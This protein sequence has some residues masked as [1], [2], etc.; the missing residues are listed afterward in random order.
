MPR[1]TKG[2]RGVAAGLPGARAAAAEAPGGSPGSERHRA[3]M[4]ER[5]AGLRAELDLRQKLA[6]QTSVLDAPKHGRDV[7]PEAS[8]RARRR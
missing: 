2:P 8:P 6:E 3:T 1:S 5:A 7:V 4:A